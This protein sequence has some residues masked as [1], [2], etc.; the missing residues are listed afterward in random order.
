MPSLKL[1]IG[2]RN[3]S[4]W[5][6]RPWLAMKANGLDFDEELIPLDTP[7]FRVA[8]AGYGAAGRVPI[9]IDGDLVIWDSLAIL[10]HLAERFPKG[11]HWWPRVDFLRAHARAAVA[12]MHSGFARVRGAMPMNLKRDPSLAPLDDGTRAEVARIEHL[13]SEALRLSGGPFLYG[14]FSIADVFYAP[15]A[16]RFRSYAVALGEPASAYVP[17][18]HAWPDF[19]AWRAAA[20][21]KVWSN[22][23]TDGLYR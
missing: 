9:L 1:I 10:E 3:Y 4:S 6:L 14:D 8:I 18:I 20:I 21:R 12:E 5:S 16:T 15:V 17:Q 23:A 13:W 7:Q 11:R 19:A 22:S 2:N